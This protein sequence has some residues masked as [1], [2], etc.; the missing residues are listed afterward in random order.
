M[1]G[2]EAC[3]FFLYIHLYHYSFIYAPLRYVFDFYSCVF[4]SLQ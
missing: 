3:F 2:E 4:L 1:N